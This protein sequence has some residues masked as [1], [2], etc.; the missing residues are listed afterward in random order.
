MKKYLDAETTWRMMDI[1]ALVISSTWV[2]STGELPTDEE[3]S[4]I[5]R[6]VMDIYCAVEDLVPC[7][8]GI[9]DDDDDEEEYDED[10]W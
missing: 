2:A 7:Y 1:A 9:I 10:E 8:E 4:T 6:S 5:A 3:T